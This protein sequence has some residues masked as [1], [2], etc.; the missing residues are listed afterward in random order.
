MGI[1]R[2][3]LEH[4]KGSGPTVNSGASIQKIGEFEK[5]NSVVLPID[6]VE[7]LTLANGFDQSR[8]Y[9]DN[10]GF[11]FWPIEYLCRVSEYAEGKWYFEKS[12][13][14]FI[15]CDYLDLSWVYALHVGDGGNGEV[16]LVG[17]H[18]EKPQVI[19]QSFSE[20][21]RLYLEN[22]SALYPI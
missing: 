15:F 3:L 16:L 18:D 11:N 10:W 8:N 14:Y 2:L 4:W 6:F 12:E 19:A 22:N 1:E 21:V 20:F 13:A 9:Q 7:Y 17:T 5:K